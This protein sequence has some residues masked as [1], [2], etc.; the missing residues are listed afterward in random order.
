MALSWVG[1]VVAPNTATPPPT[2]PK[3]HR[4]T[5]LDTI[6]TPDAPHTRTFP[7]STLGKPLFSLG[8][9]HSQKSLKNWR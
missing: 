1:G 8:V 2:Y 7:P 6:E 5:S 9:N 4:K 3:T